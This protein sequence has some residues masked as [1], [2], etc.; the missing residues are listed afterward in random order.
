LRRA[1]S[2]RTTTTSCT[3]LSRLE[4]CEWRGRFLLLHAYTDSELF[5]TLFASVWLWA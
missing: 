4:P 1:R 3:C 5:D 2:L